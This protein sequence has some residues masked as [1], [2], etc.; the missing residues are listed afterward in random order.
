MIKYFF[1]LINSLTLFIFGL[2]QTDNS[3]TI[4]NNIP[5]NF[6]VGQEVAVEFRISK[7]I[8]TGFA[9]FQLELPD[10]ISII[11]KDE[12]NSIYSIQNGVA[13]WI[14]SEV[15][16]DEE[17][18]IKLTLVASEL[19]I[20]IKTFNS[21]YSFIEK[22]EKKVFNM[23]PL[24]A[25]IQNNII[26]NNVSI[27][28]DTLTKADPNTSIDVVRLISDGPN[29]NEKTITI[30]IKKGDTKGFAKY[31]DEIDLNLNAKAIK[32]DGSSF[33]VSDGKIKF[34]WVDVPTK[35]ELEVSYHI[36]LNNKNS[37]ILKGEYSYLEKNQSKKYIV[38]PDS[39]VIGKLKDEINLHEVD[40]LR[41]QLAWRRKLLVKME[42]DGSTEKG[43]L[44]KLKHESDSLDK[45]LTLS[46]PAVQKTEAAK[47]IVQETE[48]NQLTSKKIIEDSKSNL[49]VEKTS[50]LV[51]EAPNLVKKEAIEVKTIPAK[52]EIVKETPQIVNANPNFVVQIGAFKNTKVV[53]TV[54]IKKYRITDKIVDELHDGFSKFMVGNH[55]LYKE[56]RKHR[57]IIKSKHGVKDA[58]IAA[59]NVGKRITVQEALMVS[60]QSWFKET[61]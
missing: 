49:T 35:S 53:A 2:F 34:V 56:A 1:I 26:N 13:Q 61:N 5:S 18:L 24:E 57:D 50:T 37:N 22:N 51:T 33:S 9:K 28:K 15:P 25:S 3:V 52:A 38:K 30:K 29:A 59:Y 6:I 19:G 41:K 44:D 16:E 10:G 60:K 42:S 45:L 55:N 7:G 27:I 17:L 12:M 23:L 43:K 54:L 14:W 36:D 58:F 20:G 46:W 40:E 21:N 8:Q 47:S 31:S 32:T 11:K 48:A 4:K 39:L